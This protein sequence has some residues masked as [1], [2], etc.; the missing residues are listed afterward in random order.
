VEIE[1]KKTTVKIGGQSYDVPTEETLDRIPLPL[2][3]ELASVVNDMS[4]VSQ[5]EAKS[6]EDG[7]AG[8]GAAQGTAVH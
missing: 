4:S 5:E 1:F 8:E 7:G 3:L 6:S 2:M